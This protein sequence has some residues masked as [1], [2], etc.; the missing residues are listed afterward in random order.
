MGQMF[1]ALATNRKQQDP[2]QMLQSLKSDPVGF[3]RQMGYN[4]PQ[5]IDLHNPQ[6]II[7]GLMQS[8]QIPQSA[9]SQG[10]QMMRQFPGPKK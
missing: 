4:V 9:Y 3:I 7:N 10:M 6:S 5:G 1:D 8:R 2:M